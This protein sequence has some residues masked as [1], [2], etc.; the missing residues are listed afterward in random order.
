ME[1]IDAGAGVA[2]VFGWGAHQRLRERVRK[3][4]NERTSE[5]ARHPCKDAGWLAGEVQASAKGP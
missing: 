5:R 2:E 4:V 1:G 3:R